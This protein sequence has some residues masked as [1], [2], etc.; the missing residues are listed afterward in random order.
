MSRREYIHYRVSLSKSQERAKGGETATNATA[1]TFKSEAGKQSAIARLMYETVY[2][3]IIIQD[4]VESSMELIRMQEQSGLPKCIICKDAVL[5][6]K[7]ALTACC[8]QPLYDT[9]ERTMD[10]AMLL[11][12]DAPCAAC[13]DKIRRLLEKGT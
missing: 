13:E 8:E 5:S 6:D 1:G 10:R 11:G 3:K 9:C 7:Y 12:N 4:I 2:R